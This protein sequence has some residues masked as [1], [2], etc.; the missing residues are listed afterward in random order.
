MGKPCSMDLGECVVGA[1]EPTGLSRRQAEARFGVGISTIIRWVRRLSETGRARC[2]C[3]RS[4]RAT[5]SSSTI[6]ARTRARPSDVP[7]AKPA[8]GSA[9]RRNARR[10][11]TPSGSSSPNSSTCSKKGRRAQRRRRLPCHR[12][13][14]R[15]PHRRR[16]LQRLHQ[17]RIQ[18]NL[19]SSCSRPRRSRGPR[20][21]RGRWCAETVR[22]ARARRGRRTTAPSPPS[23][24]RPRAAPPGS[25]P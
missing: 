16:M 10:T 9:S 8:P 23:P 5:S 20:I 3:P 15:H 22:R 7:S 18:S 11:R 13:N 24:D 14:P 2:S 21:R 12:P 4:G 19:S 25:A 1:A 6:P 17:S